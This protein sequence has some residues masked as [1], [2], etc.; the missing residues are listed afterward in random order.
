MGVRQQ[1]R[2][3]QKVITRAIGAADESVFL[4][5]AY[6]FPPGFLRRAL[7]QVP[8]RGARLS[9]LL[10]GSSDFCPLPGD[11]LAQTHFLG[12]FLRE[13]QGFEDRVA[14]HLYEKRHMHAKHMSVD[15]V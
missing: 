5:T 1:R 11:L 7:N 4:T 13:A 3:L 2:T 15:G 14:V 6:F 10:S 8:T 9:L 12:R